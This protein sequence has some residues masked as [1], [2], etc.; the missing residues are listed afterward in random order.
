MV[1]D[2]TLSCTS[3]SSYKCPYRNHKA[4]QRR[5]RNRKGYACYF[6]I[7]RKRSDKQEFSI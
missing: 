2:N 1:D 5:G 4:T 3:E 7:R 6:Q